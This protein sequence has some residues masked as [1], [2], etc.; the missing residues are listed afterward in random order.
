M[1]LIDQRRLPGEVS[2]IKLKDLDEMAEAISSLAVRG[3]PAIGAF[4]GLAL[5]FLI[6]GGKGPDECYDVLVKTRPTAVD[7]K[8]VLDRVLGGYDKGGP[9]EARRISDDIVSG[10][11]ESCRRIGE[12]GTEVI[13][14]GSRV[15]THCNA[16]ALA[17]LD[18]GTALAPVRMVHRGGGD[19]FVWVSETRP[20]LQ[21]SRLTAWELLQEGIPHKIFVDSASGYLMK[22]GEVDTLITGADRVCVNGDTA[23]KI[24]TFEKAL[25]AREFGI[26][27]YV[28]IPWST[29]DPELKS[30]EGIPIEVR[31]GSELTKLDKTVLAPDG[32][33]C[34]NPA[35]DVTPA[36]YITGFIT[37]DGIFTPEELEAAWRLHRIV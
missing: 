10:T 23:N 7:L 19:I 27:F 37:P 31:D 29:F 24:G 3:A 34:V 15:M 17:T 13:G 20:L 11:V 30:G 26:P 2:L 16:G 36:E 1:V 8:H 28:A 4:G 18:W 32:S 9:D 35:F 21:G 22:N 14:D 33:E 25:L 12:A 5:S 6:D